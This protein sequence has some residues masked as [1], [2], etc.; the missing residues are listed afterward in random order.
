MFCFSGFLTK[1]FSGFGFFLTAA[2]GLHPV[3]GGVFPVPPAA[4]VLMK[5]LPP[6]TCFTVSCTVLIFSYLWF[7]KVQYVKSVLVCYRVLLFK[8][9]SSWKP[10]GDAHFLRVS[11]FCPILDKISVF[12]VMLVAVN[13][14]WFDML[15]RCFFFFLFLQLLTL[16]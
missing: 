3:P 7:K 14:H 2:P 5:L 10:S 9:M 4:V 16:L 11:S 15:L 1:T 8:W 13:C 6:P 12:V